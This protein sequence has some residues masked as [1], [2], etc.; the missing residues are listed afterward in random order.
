MITGNVIDLH[1][2]IKITFRLTDGSYREIEFVVDTGFT[3]FL[4][5]PPQEIAALGLSFA[6]RTRAYL[7]DH[8]EV[9]LPVHIGA[10]IWDG[11]ELDVR[12]LATGQRPL[13][14]TALLK[15]Y[16]LR[17]QFADMGL[18]SAEEL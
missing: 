4:T 7:A 1:A 12:V 11:K 13:L 6:Y 2:L 16:E 18:V 5:L 17:A 9:R 15:G 10:I 8:S 14:G 3:G